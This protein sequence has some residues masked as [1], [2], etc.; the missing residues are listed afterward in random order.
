MLVWIFQSFLAVFVCIL[1]VATTM[2]ML[3]LLDDLVLNGYFATK[4]RKRFNVKDLQ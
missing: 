4:L 2:F 3:F 1:L